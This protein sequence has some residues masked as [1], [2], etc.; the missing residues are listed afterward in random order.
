MTTAIESCTRFF[1]HLIL[2][3]KTDLIGL[4]PQV[5][6]FFFFFVSILLILI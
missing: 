2:V 3:E 6:F 1:P 5:D 4:K